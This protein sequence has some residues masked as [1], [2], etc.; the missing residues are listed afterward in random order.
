MNKILDFI[1]K[2]F[3][4]LV[5]KGVYLLTTIIVLLIG[6]L[7]IFNGYTSEDNLL[8]TIYLSIGTSLIAAGIV[9]ILDIW[10]EALKDNIFKKVKAVIIRGG[11]D[12]VYEKRDLDKYDELIK[13]VQSNIDI[14]GYSLRAFYQS[15]KDILIKKLRKIHSS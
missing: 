9:A 6:Y 11:F 13:N 15:Y 5:K 1:N 7:F 3:Y 8:G 2:V 10:R 14:T 12:Y 4:Y